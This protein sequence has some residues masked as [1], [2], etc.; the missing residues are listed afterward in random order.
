M[1]FPQIIDQG[2]S[3]SRDMT[4]R[5]KFGHVMDEKILFP[6]MVPFAAASLLIADTRL[7]RA[8]HIEPTAGLE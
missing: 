6:L 3:Q 2:T 8:L 5:E 7:G 4:R 1:K